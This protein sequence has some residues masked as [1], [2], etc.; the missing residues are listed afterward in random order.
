MNVWGPVIGSIVVGAIAGFLHLTILGL[1]PGAACIAI[2]AIWLNWASIVYAVEKDQGS[3]RL[4]FWPTT[5]L[6]ATAYAYWTL[7]A[8]L[9]Q[10]PG[11]FL[12]N[13]LHH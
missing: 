8:Y 11:F 1:L 12:L 6:T 4:P 10:L 3:G 5:G 13:W 7:K 9:L 2:G